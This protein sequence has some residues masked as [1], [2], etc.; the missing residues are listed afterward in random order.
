FPNPEDPIPIDFDIHTIPENKNRPEH[1]HLD[2]RYMLQTQYPASLN[3]SEGE[4][5]DFIWAK[6]QE[7]LH[8]SDPTD[9]DLLDPSLKRLIR[10]CE[11][12]YNFPA[13]YR[14]Q[15]R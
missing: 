3:P 13:K 7:L 6:Y 14:T 9:A 4:S 1:L 11:D 15:A 8:P 10:K 2:L 5:K 12:C